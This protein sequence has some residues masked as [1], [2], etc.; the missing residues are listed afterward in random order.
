[1]VFFGK[2]AERV[3]FSL[4][5]LLFLV[6]S[7]AASP[8]QAMG[9]R[10]FTKGYQDKLRNLFESLVLKIESGE[11]D[12]AE[13]KTT[14]GRLRSQYRVQYDDFA[15]KIDAIIDEVDE[16]KRDPQD[17]IN[18][19]LVIQ[20]DL[21]KSQGMVLTN[22]NIRAVTPKEGSSAHET[23]QGGSSPGGGP[24]GESSSGGGSSSRKNK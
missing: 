1:M 13:A 11:I 23:R 22:A 19:F 7:F 9:S 15:G 16:K 12:G 6:F 5:L 20:N 17:A 4:P 21:M 10:E 24:S 14:M 3:L 2:K 8:V 18:F